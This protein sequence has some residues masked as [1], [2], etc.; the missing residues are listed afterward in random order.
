VLALVPRATPR[1]LPKALDFGAG[2]ADIFANVAMVA[3]G[4]AAIPRP[5]RY[6]D[7]AKKYGTVV[8]VYAAVSRKA[9][10]V[11]AVPLR[12]VTRTADGVTEV[13]AEHQLRRLLTGINDF[14]TQMEFMESVSANLD[15]S[16][17]AYC[18][19]FS[20][21]RGVPQELWPIRPDLVEVIA[22]PT[23]YIAGYRITAG[24][25]EF[26]FAAEQVLHFREF[27][28]FSDYYGLGALT[29]AW[30]SAIIEEESQLWNRSLMRNSGR[31]DGLITSDQ[32]I[33]KAQA[34]EAAERLRELITGPR[35]AGRIGVVGRGMKYAQIA[36]TPKGLD[37]VLSRK[38]TREEILAAIGVRPVILGLE[39]GDI[40][41]RSEQ[42]RDYFYATIRQRLHKIIGTLN[43]FLVPAF[44]EPGLEII[45]DIETALLPYEDREALAR[46]DAL[47]IQ[48][49]IM[50]PNEVRRRRGLPPVEGG[51]VVLVPISMIPV[52]QAG[53]LGFGG[54]PAGSL[55]WRKSDDPRLDLWL[56]FVAKAA[57]LEQS[58]LVGLARAFAATRDMLVAAITDGRDPLTAL[59]ESLTTLARLLHGLAGAEL[60][61]AMEA[62]FARA[63][64]LVEGAMKHA[65]MAQR[66]ADRIEANW[67]GRKDAAAVLRFD[68][69]IP[70]LAEYL[71][72]RPAVYADLVTASLSEQFRQLLAEQ[73]NAGASID[74]MAA[75]VTSTFDTIT[76]Q[77]ALLIARTEVIS[78]SNLAAHVAYGQAAEAGVDVQQGWLSARDERVRETHRLA[79]GQVV[80]LDQPFRVGNALLRYPGD[81][82]GPIEEIA[83]CRCTTVPQVA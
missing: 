24:R 33:T 50:L 47:D 58:F 39:T 57:P 30:S 56:E 64:A 44:R 23:D 8:W 72:Q 53:T 28:P 19:V 65:T 55:A 68:L 46:A 61:R 15:L 2:A 40:G 51:D 11:S 5:Q 82:S 36:T 48:N 69:A 52:D 35:N 41:R 12:V 81:P 67:R 34:D 20:N 14:S 71:R 45:A 3:Q 73:A 25:E 43:E 7:L 27:N 83:A 75:A 42:I 66:L 21:G 78:A 54:A 17:N 13:K 6:E 9:K 77:R 49:R 80:A 10:D 16:G 29:P 62:G 26:T 1:F 63:A 59:T 4:G 70:E 60:P 31:M 22:S 38:L 76:A 32:S 79:D 74:Q 18:L 37:F